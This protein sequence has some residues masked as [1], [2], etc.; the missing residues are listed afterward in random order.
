[1]FYQALKNSSNFKSLFR[2][3]YGMFINIDIELTKEYLKILIKLIPNFKKLIYDL[4]LQDFNYQEVHF[5]YNDGFTYWEKLKTNDKSLRWVMNKFD[6]ILYFIERPINLTYITEKDEKNIDYIT[7]KYILRNYNKFNDIYSLY[8]KLIEYIEINDFYYI[9]FNCNLEEL[10]K[11]ILN[12]NYF[13][14]NQNKNFLYIIAGKIASKRRALN[15][16][17][18]YNLKDKDIYKYFLGKEC[19]NKDK[20]IIIDYLLNRLSYLEYGE[21]LKVIAGSKGKGQDFI[22]RITSDYLNYLLKGEIKKNNYISNLITNCDVIKTYSEELDKIPTIKYMIYENKLKKIERNFL[23][24]HTESYNLYFST[25]MAKIINK[26]HP[27][28]LEKLLTCYI[29]IASCNLE[30]T[31][32]PRR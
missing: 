30:E 11:I 14:S 4:G 31:P 19:L 29:N 21:V 1:M 18:V 6:L 32:K 27:W 10:K 23:K 16:K 7:I 26:P 15:D 17:K 28:T 12:F 3:F 2:N 9:I 24:T 13:K 22:G 20:Q 25:T 8:C 5:Y